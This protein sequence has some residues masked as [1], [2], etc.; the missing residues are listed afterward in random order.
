MQVGLGEKKVNIPD[1]SCS[2]QEFRDI[3]VA[4]F[5]KLNGCGASIFYAVFQTLKNLR[6]FSLAVSQ[7]PKLLKS[8]VGGGK[9]FIH[10]IQ[11]DLDLDLDKQLIA[12]V[13]VC[14]TLI[15]STCINLCQTTMIVLVGYEEVHPLREGCAHAKFAEACAGLKGKVC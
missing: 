1:I 12:L 7:S 9:V 3:V 10:P 13:E 14:A 11:Q 2:P 8:V 6:P 5:P 4:G 15:T